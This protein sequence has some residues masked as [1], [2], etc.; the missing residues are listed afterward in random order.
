ML[1]YTHKGF[2]SIIQDFKDESLV[3]VRGK[4]QDDILTYF[5][6]AEVA[7]DTGTDYKFR[8]SLTKV[9]VAERL[10]KY[11]LS[12]LNVRHWKR[13]KAKEKKIS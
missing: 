5:P 1:L 7:I 4:F 8:T 2:L 11:V 10:W 13:K 12:E 3:I 9:E 6:S